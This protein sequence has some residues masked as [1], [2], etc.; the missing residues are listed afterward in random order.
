MGINVPN[1]TIFTGDNLEV[2]KGINSNSVDLV[3][4]DPPFNSN[5][6]Y[7]AQVGTIATGTAFDDVWKPDESVYKSLSAANPN[8][9]IIVDPIDLAHSKSM[10]AYLAM[11]GMRLLEIHRIL[12]D[13][14]SIY[15]HI[16]STSSHYL[17]I[18]MDYIFGKDNFR[19][20][21]FW[22]RSG[23]KGTKGAKRTFGRTTDTILFYSKSNNYKFEIPKVFDPKREKDFKYTDDIG[24][25][26]RAVTTLYGDPFLL[27]GVS[28]YEW[29]NH[30]PE[31]GWR[32]SKETLERLHTADKIHYNRSNRPYR[33]EYRSEYK[34]TDITNVW[35]DISVASGKERTGYPTQKPLALLERIIKTSSNEGDTILDPFCG[36]ATTC[37]AS[38]K[39]NRSWIGIDISNKSYEI[40]MTRLPNSH[41]INR[42]IAPQRD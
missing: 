26:Y 6:T 35:D 4:L 2:M 41:L 42:W 40:A 24:G 31:H 18:I 33:K 39:L 27:G 15:L 25:P 12:K 19:N 36:S 38:E 29:N 20:E 13:T 21:I 3:Y 8:L 28:Y 10:K 30:N 9:Y 7:T 11:M 14:G 34:G 1:R 22:K 16:D 17:K 23:S 32:V 37:I 5:A